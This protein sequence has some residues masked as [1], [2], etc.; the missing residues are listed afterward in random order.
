MGEDAIT[1]LFSKVE[2]IRND[3]S[4]IKTKIEEREKRD[5]DNN[6]ENRIKSLELWRAAQQGI[7]G[8]IQR[9]GPVAISAGIGIFVATRGGGHG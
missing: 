6:H 2:E 4:V 5:D 9:W 7:S 1:R 8:F 3:V